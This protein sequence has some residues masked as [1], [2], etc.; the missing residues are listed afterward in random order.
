MSVRDIVLPTA[1]DDRLR[2]RAEDD[3]LRLD[4]EAG[5]ALTRPKVT[6]LGWGN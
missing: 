1:T 3:G 6:V 4:F 2:R 5:Y